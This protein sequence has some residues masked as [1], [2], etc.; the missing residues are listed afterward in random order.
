MPPHT[1]GVEQVAALLSRI[2]ADAGHEVRWIACANPERPGREAQ[3]G[4]ELVRLRAFNGL[5]SRFAMPFPVPVPDAYA[6]I[7]QAVRAAEV[8]HLHDCLYPTSIAADASTET[9]CATNGASAA[10]T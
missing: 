4:L 6:Q 9:T 10:L 1:G 2:Y 8:V 7:D 3:N 5:E